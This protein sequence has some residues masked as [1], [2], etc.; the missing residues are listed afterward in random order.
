M[1]MYCRLRA[2]T[3]EEAGRLRVTPAAAYH[4]AGRESAVS[5]EKAWHGIHFLLTG[6]AWEG[7]APLN[8]LLE[9]GEA[10]GADDPD[11][12]PGARLFSPEATRALDMAL[13]GVSD[14]QLWE[15]FDADRM[16]KEGVYPG[17]WDEPEDDLRE[18]YVGYFHAMKELIHRACVANRALLVMIG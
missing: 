10:I 2:L 17:I 8:F 11:G 13:A 1:G 16:T 18:E 15:Q 7:E 14:D 12:G 4:G 6:S 3:P 5:L 9:G